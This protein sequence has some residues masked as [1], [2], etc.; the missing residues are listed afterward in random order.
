MQGILTS[1]FM[2]AIFFWAVASVILRE[3]KFH[4]MCN[5]LIEYFTFL[6]EIWA[7]KTRNYSENEIIYISVFAMWNKSTHKIK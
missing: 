5:A 4:K 2:P 6:L 7:K 3:N 1:V